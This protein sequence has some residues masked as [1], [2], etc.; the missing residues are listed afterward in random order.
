[1]KKR[2][3]KKQIW[4]NEEEAA[5][6]AEKAERCCLT[7]ASL[8][9]MMMTDKTIKEQPSKEFFDCLKSLY[10]LGSNINQ[11]YTK[12]NSLGIEDKRYLLTTLDR[13][14]DLISKCEN[15][16]LSCEEV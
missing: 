7:E 6:L 15:E 3:I 2:N 16:F 11:V 9:R 5:A 1:M 13:I 14:N 8:M 10:K 4:V 12:F